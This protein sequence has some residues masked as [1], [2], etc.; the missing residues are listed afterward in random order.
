[1]YPLKRGEI[2]RE[3]SRILAWMLQF[4]LILLKH[5]KA[6]IGVYEMSLR[7]NGLYG[8]APLHCDNCSEDI[9]VCAIR[10][11]AY[12]ESLCLCSQR[13]LFHLKY[14]WAPRA[15]RQRIEKIMRYTLGNL[16]AI[17]I[18]SRIGA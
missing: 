16:A 17:I 2:I 6:T 5:D 11:Y 12:K 1:M 10:T 18:M 4:S 8:L 9:D 3:I 15:K 13:C 14:L 7:L